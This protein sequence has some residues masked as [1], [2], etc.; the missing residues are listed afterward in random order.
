MVSSTEQELRVRTKL[1]TER[2]KALLRLK[3]TLTEKQ[4]EDLKLV[5]ETAEVQGNYDWNGE[6]SVWSD[7]V[8]DTLM[9]LSREF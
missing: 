1:E 4:I 5:I 3:S 9:Q 7:D 8:N 6:D 2:S